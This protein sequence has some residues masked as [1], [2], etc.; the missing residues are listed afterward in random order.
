MNVISSREVSPPFNQKQH[1][2]RPKLKVAE[3]LGI[4]RV[5]YQMMGDLANKQ[6]SD[7]DPE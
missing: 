5:G 3:R 6:I 1:S 4:G 7:S 2:T